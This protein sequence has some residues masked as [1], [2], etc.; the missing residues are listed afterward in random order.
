MSEPGFWFETNM[1]R[2]GELFMKSLWI[3]GQ[4]VDLLVFEEHPELVEPFLTTPAT[5]PFEFALL[6]AELWQKDFS[7]RG[8]HKRTDCNDCEH[9]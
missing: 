1:A 4:I 2:A 5:V 6:R 3:Q 8:T 7:P 9:C